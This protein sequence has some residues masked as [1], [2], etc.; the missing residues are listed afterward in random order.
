MVTVIPVK[1]QYFKNIYHH[2]NLKLIFNVS[3][4]SKDL[5]NTDDTRDKSMAME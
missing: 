1:L 2:E 5:C 4:F 3:L